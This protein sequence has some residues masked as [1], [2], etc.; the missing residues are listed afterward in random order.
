MS[1]TANEDRYMA[2]YRQEGPDDRPQCMCYVCS[3]PGCAEPAERD[4][5]GQ[6]VHV[7]LCGLCYMDHGD[8]ALAYAE[9]NL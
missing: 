1:W 4:I 8:K 2:E 5:I 6:H 7:Q 9:A 3:S